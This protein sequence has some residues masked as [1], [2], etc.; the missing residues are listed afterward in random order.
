MGLGKTIMMIALML[1]NRKGQTLIITPLSLM[2]QWQS[3]I[4][5]FGPSL[6]VHIYENNKLTD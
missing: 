4:N 3:Q 2:K 6:N 1:A 5:K